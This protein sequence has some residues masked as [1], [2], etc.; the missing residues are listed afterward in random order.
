MNLS[1]QTACYQFH[2]ALRI[3]EIPPAV[4]VV[5]NPLVIPTYNEGKTSITLSGYSAVC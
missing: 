2:P 1:P 5:L 4:G 3:T